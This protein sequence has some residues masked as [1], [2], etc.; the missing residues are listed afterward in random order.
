MIIYDNFSPP[1]DQIPTEYNKEQTLRFIRYIIEFQAKE[2]I[3]Q[4]LVLNVIM[5]L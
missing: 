2:E 1:K 3:K 4:L 5:L